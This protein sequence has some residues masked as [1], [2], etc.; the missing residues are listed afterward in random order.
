MKENIEILSKKCKNKS[1]VF[2]CIGNL[3]EEIYE[4]F[5]LNKLFNIKALCDIKFESNGFYKGF[6][7]IPTKELK[8][9]PFEYLIIVSPDFDTKEKFLKENNFLNKKTKILNIQQKKEKINSQ[10]KYEKII[11]N[12]KN[13]EKLKV[14]FICE[15]NENGATQIYTKLLKT[16][17]SLK[18]FRS[19]YFL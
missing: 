5:N 14:L 18:S 3:F 15:Q 9:I 2:Y 6:P 13:K 17:K 7:S 11:K 10:K 19:P 1:V 4:N 16:T 8:D 12:F